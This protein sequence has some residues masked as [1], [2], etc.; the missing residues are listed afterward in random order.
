MMNKVVV[1]TC[2]KIAYPEKSADFRPSRRYPEY[3]PAWPLMNMA[4]IRSM[5]V[6]EMPL[7]AWA[8]IRNIREHPS[9]IL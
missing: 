8:T 3:D 9:G 7:Y 1:E 2:N 5:T 6:F 4:T